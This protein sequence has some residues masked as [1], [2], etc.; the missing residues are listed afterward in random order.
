MSLIAIPICCVTFTADLYP[1]KPFIINRSGE[2]AQHLRAHTVLPEKAS[3]IFSIHIR[4]LITLCNSN[5][6]GSNSSVVTCTHV[7]IPIQDTQN[8]FVQWESPE[9]NRK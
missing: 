4:Q 6:R 3:L 1:S 5:S 9:E 8:I 2:T 7:R